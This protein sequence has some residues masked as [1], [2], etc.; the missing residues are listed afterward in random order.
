MRQAD[1]RF[2]GDVPAH[3][4]RH[5]GPVMYEPCARHLV[6]R[7]AAAAAP[8]QRILEAACGT[9]I[10]TRRILELLPAGA[11]VTAT[12]LNQPMMDF[13]ARALNGDARIEWRAADAQSLPFEDA[14]FDAYVC[15]FGYMFMADRVL[16]A[17]EAHR[18]LER[19]GRL[20][21]NTWE[22]LSRNPFAALADEV[23]AR[24]FPTDPPKFYRTPFGWFDEAELR[25]TFEAAGFRD[26]RIEPVGLPTRTESAR[27]FATGLVRGSPVALEIAERGTAGHDAVIDAL[28]VALAFEGGAEPFE[29]VLRT[30]LITAIA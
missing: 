28:A 27:H 20:L 18:V 1:A 7:L 21:V 11:R 15:Q 8:P 13:A 19:G 4:H 5:L 12:D 23:I 2:L 6:V 24:Y 25:L 29:T 30:L 14:S 17:R 9:G 3:Y 26:L 22:R 16:A 10:A